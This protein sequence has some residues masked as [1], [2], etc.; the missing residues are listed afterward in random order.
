MFQMQRNDNCLGVNDASSNGPVLKKKEMINFQQL[1]KKI[2][3]LK[4][5]ITPTVGSHSEVN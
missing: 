3:S 2:Y 4:S 5:Y 1:N